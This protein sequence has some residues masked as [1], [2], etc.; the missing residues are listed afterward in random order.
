MSIDQFLPSFGS[1]FNF[2]TVPN[3]SESSSVQEE[4][5]RAT[6]AEEIENDE[7]VV[8]ELTDHPIQE[9]SDLNII[10]LLHKLAVHQIG[11]IGEH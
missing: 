7:Q 10:S 3:T 2:E 5:M 6:I 8:P 9:F 1:S 11:Q 4:E